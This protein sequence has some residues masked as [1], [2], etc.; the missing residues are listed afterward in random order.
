MFRYIT[1][2]YVYSLTEWSKSIRFLSERQISMEKQDMVNIW[3]THQV[4][5][6]EVKNEVRLISRDEREVLNRF[7]SELSFGTGGL[8]GILGAGTNR[9]NIY[10]VARATQ[11]LAEYLKSQNGKSVAIAY[12]SRN[13][14]REFAMI[15]AGV[16]A[17]NGIQAY[18]FNRIMPTPILSF[19]I[20]EMKCDAGIVITASHNPAQYNGY[21]VYGADGCQITDYAAAVITAYIEKVSYGELSW[22]SEQEARLSGMLQ[23][24]PEAV[25]IAY[26]EKTLSCRIEKSA[27]P[28]TLRMV[29]TPLHG[30]GLEP[31][32][33]VLNQMGVTQC[34]EVTEQCTPDGNFPTCPK[35]NPEIQETLRL[36]ID[37]AKREN[38]EDPDCDRIG[39]AVRNLSGE[40]QILTG[41]EVGLLLTE[42]LLHKKME[43]GVLHKDALVVKTIVTSDLCFAIAERYGVGVREVLTGFKYI[44]ETIGQ[45]EKTG[46]EHHFLFGFEESCGYLA[47]THVRDKDG[48]MACM[49]IAD[50]AQYYA[51]QSQTLLDA[52]EKLYS[53]YGYMQNQLLN[54]DIEDALP[55]QKMQAIMS[56]LRANPP[57]IIGEDTIAVIKDYKNGLDGLP[58]SDVLS[59]ESEQGDKAIIRPS[60]TEPKIKVY[61]SVKGKSKFTTEKKL[62][63]IVQQVDFWINA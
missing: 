41:N 34:I 45:L 12:D 48:V 38:A 26:I 28:F 29:Y 39:V 55:M 58:I 9:M 23:D 13:Y 54:Y 37:T 40:Y 10:T 7:G 22:L 30:T 49:L 36:A 8:R 51:F 21:K 20:R 59:F 42:Y 47:G 43:K 46:M 35:P 62:K 32:R 52:L 17:H 24:I 19:S 4:F 60:G 50:M 56:K 3:M 31:I 53:T 14:S 61:L 63:Y 6:T 16:L 11:G 2:L 57:Q 1:I 44:G 15:V 25:Y 5:S 27:V 18:C 33:D